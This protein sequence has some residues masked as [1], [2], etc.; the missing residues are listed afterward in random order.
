MYKPH[1]RKL[2]AVFYAILLLFSLALIVSAYT[3]N[4]DTIVY[5]TN[6]GSK[7]H[8]RSCGYLRS[9]NA[10][11]LEDAIINGFTPCSRCNPPK[12]TGTAKPYEVK[13]TSSSRSSNKGSSVQSSTTP[14]ASTAEVTEP[15]TTKPPETTT[16]E[17]VQKDKETNGATVE[18]IMFLFL[19]SFF[20]LPFLS[21]FV[22]WL[23]SA[24][25]RIVCETRDDK[26]RFQNEQ[27]MY[28]QLSAAKKQFEDALDVLA[29]KFDLVLSREQSGSKVLENVA[30]Q[31]TELLNN[32]LQGHNARI[33][34]SGLVWR[35]DGVCEYGEDFTVYFSKNS[36]SYHLHSCYR[37]GPLSTHIL[38]VPTKL[39]P[40]KICRPDRIDTSWMERARSLHERISEERLEASC[41]IDTISGEA[42]RRRLFAVNMLRA[43]VQCEIVPA[44]SDV[45]SV[46][47]RN[48]IRVFFAKLFSVSFKV[49]VLA[50]PV[51]N[52]PG[53]WRMDYN[54]GSFG[55]YIY[56]EELKVQ[57]LKCVKQIKKHADAKGELYR[58]N[59]GKRP[60]V[61]PNCLISRET[62]LRKKSEL[63][64]Q[65]RNEK[66]LKK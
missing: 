44:D 45:L 38:N 52:T 65:L 32:M 49:N 5:V 19:S 30:R 47:C 34:P 28:L 43:K 21:R 53:K 61:Y 29:D 20:V 58:I 7:Y 14:P 54:T 37:R 57:G 6:T 59:R 60:P 16:S 39:V 48:P 1:A 40:C 56:T 23:G 62:W 4:G 22:L 10:I 36:S 50:L 9:V 3:G 24:I 27:K 13:E 63:M 17:I 31:E 42:A 26:H 46:S 66:C 51:E 41:A 12:Y 35:A 25:K 15:L 64:E 33:R 8:V 18:I 11:Y 55:K 2:T